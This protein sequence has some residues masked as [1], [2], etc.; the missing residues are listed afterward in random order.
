MRSIFK[1]GFG[2]NEV[3]CFSLGVHQALMP[4][5]LA[6]E[7]PGHEPWEPSL[8]IHPFQP[9]SSPFRGRCPSVCPL[10]CIWL[11]TWEISSPSWSLFPRPHLHSPMYFLFSNLSLLDIFLTTTTIPSMLVNLCVGSPSSPS[12]LTGPDAF[13]HHLVGQPKGLLSVMA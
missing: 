1:D 13:P 11:S 9:L 4:L 6:L 5:F 8:W 10:A 12:Q 3:I 7:L 2:S